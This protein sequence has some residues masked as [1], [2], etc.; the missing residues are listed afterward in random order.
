MSKKQRERMV[1]LLEERYFGRVTDGGLFRKSVRQTEFKGNNP[2][3]EDLAGNA[4]FALA[5]LQ[6]L[7]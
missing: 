2:G 4:L 3:R 5:F 7:R 6:P 1:M